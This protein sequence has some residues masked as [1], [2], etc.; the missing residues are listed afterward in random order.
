MNDHMSKFPK[1]HFEPIPAPVTKGQELDL[2]VEAISHRGNSGVA[3]ISGYLV[4]IPGTQPGDKVHVRITGV[5]ERWATA[6]KIT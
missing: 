4:F 1:P 3:K 6:Q 5:T 2:T